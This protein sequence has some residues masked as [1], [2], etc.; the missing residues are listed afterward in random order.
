MGK[1]KEN[2]EGKAE[3]NDCANVSCERGEWY[4]HRDKIWVICPFC[5]PY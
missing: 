3:E 1:E 5:N 4:C 2:K